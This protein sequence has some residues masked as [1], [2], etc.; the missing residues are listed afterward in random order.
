PPPTPAPAEPDMTPFSLSDLGLSD[1]E[2]ASLGMEPTPPSTQQTAPSSPPVDDIFDFDITAEQPAKG[3]AQEEPA[4]E[5]TEIQPF[6]LDDLGLGDDVMGGFG[7]ADSSS[8]E[9]SLTEEELAG[10]DLGPF[11][12]NASPTRP[13]ARSDETDYAVDTGDPVLDQLIILG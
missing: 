4:E 2:I 6:S 3:A 1:E 10:M 13:S 5:D 7:A 11:E 12:K 8:S 9:L